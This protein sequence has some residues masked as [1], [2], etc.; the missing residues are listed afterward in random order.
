M[1]AFLGESLHYAVVEPLGA[2]LRQQAAETLAEAVYLAQQHGVFAVLQLDVAR[3][4]GFV[5]VVVKVELIFRH[6]GS[7]Q[8][9]V[10]RDDVAPVDLDGYAVNH[11]FLGLVSPK[12]PLRKHNVGC[13]YND[14]QAYKY[15]KPGDMHVLLDDR[16]V[17]EVFHL[18]LTTDL[19][20]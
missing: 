10:G 12:L 1:A 20:D 3:R 4:V 2:L 19:S 18:F 17:R 14:K 6:I 5:D 7:Q 15:A 11:A 13:F 8:L 16:F 9:P